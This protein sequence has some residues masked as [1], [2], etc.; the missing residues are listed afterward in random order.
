MAT[1]RMNAMSRNSHFGA[2]VRNAEIEAAQDEEAAECKHEYGYEL[3]N[4]SGANKGDP[5]LEDS[6]GCQHRYST[7]TECIHKDYGMYIIGRSNRSRQCHIYQPARQQAIQ[8][9][10]H[11]QGKHTGACYEITELLFDLAGKGQLHFKIATWDECQHTN[12]Q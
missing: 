4:V 9:T 10:R 1:T 7:Q 8:H 6:N 5:T 3:A 2:E 12:E 11:K